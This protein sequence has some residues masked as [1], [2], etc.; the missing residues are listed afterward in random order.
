VVEDLLH[1]FADSKER[2]REI[3]IKGPSS[4]MD[5]PLITYDF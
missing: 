4:S 5:P 2:E 1:I 3:D